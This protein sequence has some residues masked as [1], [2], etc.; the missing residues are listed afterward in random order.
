[1]CLAIPGRVL[2]VAGSGLDARGLVRFGAVE[3]TVNL[4]FTPEARIGDY[5]IVHVGCAIRVLDQDEARRSLALL[6][7]LQSGERNDAFS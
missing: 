2:S 4:S 1:M 7:E 5:V 3:R 6:E